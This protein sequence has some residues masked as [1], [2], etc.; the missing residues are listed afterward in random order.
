MIPYL[1]LAALLTSVC[2][3]FYWSLL[4]SEKLF[5]TN[6]WFL[7]AGIILSFTL[8][9]VKV[10]KQ[11]IFDPT[12]I[13]LL[14][15]QV[16]FETLLP[17]VKKQGQLSE[18]VSSNPNIINSKLLVS[19]K[20]YSLINFIKTIVFYLYWMGVIISTF[21]FL[22][23]IAV[24]SYMILNNPVLKDGHYHIVTTQKD[25]A[26]CSFGNY[27]FI[28]K[29]KY[30][31]QTSSLILL[32]EK[33][34]ANQLHSFDLILSE[35]LLIIQWC[36]PF[37]WYYRT[38]IIN[39][40]EYLTDESVL[41]A[42]TVDTSEYQ[43][44]LLKV[45]SNKFI[46]ITLNYNRPLIKK[47][48][49]MMNSEKPKTNKR[50]KY[51]LLLPLLA[52]LLSVFNKSNA[53]NNLIFS[54][55]KLIMDTVKDQESKIQGDWSA[56]LID[57]DI[58]FHFKDSHNVISNIDA[59]LNDV[60][61]FSSGND[62][63]FTL[64]KWAGSIVFKGNFNGSKG[65]GEYTFSPNKEMEDLLNGLGV[66]LERG[67]SFAFFAFNIKKEF[68]ECL[69]TDSIHDVTTGNLNLSAMLDVDDQYITMLKN[70]GFTNMGL[71][72]IIAAK[73]AAIDEKYIIDMKSKY[74]KLTLDE[75]LISK[76]P[77]IKG[78]SLN[79]LIEENSKPNK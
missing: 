45:C 16:K 13:N 55:T 2:L 22:I 68:L 67:D 10:P 79:A 65:S 12:T 8:P 49:I 53:S 43:L 21:Y 62:L 58:T 64:K 75:L 69:K 74:N 50:W 73:T 6:R 44:S 11:F 32:H 36:N 34:H 7:L 76:N 54:K 17:A 26:P 31:S 48:I 23:R 15:A 72:Q 77:G 38:A 24:L 35:I 3:I 29:G 4:K 20:P 51:L 39:N 33:I 30:D 28:N 61:G 42:D 14:P 40:L 71:S 5:K 70:E 9:A 57:Q 46:N 25:H 27:I 52:L 59:N 41:E 60:Y 18:R 37:A 19:G 63:T 66:T 56:T 78:A 1:S 47:R